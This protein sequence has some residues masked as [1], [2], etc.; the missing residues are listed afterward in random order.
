[1]EVVEVRVKLEVSFILAAAA[2][3]LFGVIVPGSPEGLDV[4]NDPNARPIPSGITKLGAQR[5][6]CKGDVLTFYC[7]SSRP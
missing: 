2:V 4:L 6:A 3:T 1:M 5:E 7:S